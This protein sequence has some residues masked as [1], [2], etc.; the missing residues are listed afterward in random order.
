MLREGANFFLIEGVVDGSVDVAVAS[1]RRLAEKS[2]TAGMKF[3]GECEQVDTDG[4]SISEEI[5]I[6]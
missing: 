4:C 1:L 2:L 5:A 6:G 3:D